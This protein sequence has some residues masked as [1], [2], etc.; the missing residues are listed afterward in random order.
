MSLEM[1]TVTFGEHTIAVALSLMPLALIDVL[2]EVDHTA[3]ALRQPIDPVA[4]VTIPIFV[5]EGPSSVLLVLVPVTCV[6]T[7][8]LVTFVLPVGALTVALIN[9]PHA[10]VLVAIFVKLNAEAFLAVVAPVADILLRG[11]PFLALNGAVLRL[12]L[13]FHPVDGAMGTVFL[14]LRVVTNKQ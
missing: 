9:R 3:F 6:L 12:V 10:L 13:L 1:I 14:S 11:L 2:V 4:V 7:S 5:E 8:Q